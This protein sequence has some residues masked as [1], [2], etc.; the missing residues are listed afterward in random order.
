M[1]VPQVSVFE[2]FNYQGKSQ[3]FGL[4][5]FD[6]SALNVVGNDAISSVR[7]PPG[8]K[9][10]L[11]EHAGFQGRAI[12][13]VSDMFAFTGYNDFCS[14]LRVEYAISA[15]TLPARFALKSMANGKYVCAENAGN[16]PLIANRDAP[17][18]GTGSWEIFSA[19]KIVKNSESIWLKATVNGLLV[20][21]SASGGPLV[22][23]ATVCM[24]SFDSPQLY[25]VVPMGINR[26]ALRAQSNGQFVCA[27]SGGASPLVA[28]RAVANPG[29]ADDN[30]S[31]EIF[32]VYPM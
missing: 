32:E 20:A 27:E 29:D 10:T 6:L 30:G 22:A 31:W 4:G 25:T 14:S 26:I 13:F 12:E 21:S 15:G 3:S 16:G 18:A 2:H 8:L 7:V 17:Y 5:S 19:W 24:L 23:N 28:N 11:F 9:L 1:P